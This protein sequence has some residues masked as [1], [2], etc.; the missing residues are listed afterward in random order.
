MTDV[1]MT[2][3]T[4]APESPRIQHSLFAPDKRTA[5]RNAQETRFRAYGLVAIVIALLMLV[6]LLFSIFSAGLP[7]FRQTFV[8][9]PIVL[10]AKVL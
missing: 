10:D 2:E 7:A 9:I 4:A 3:P 8:E 1:P 6:W 5:A